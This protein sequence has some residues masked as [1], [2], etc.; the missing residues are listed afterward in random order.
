MNRA[1]GRTALA[2]ALTLLPQTAW[3]Q[4][5]PA[6]RGLSVEI[7]APR[8]NEIVFGRTRIVAEV[9]IDDPSR[10]DRVEFFLGDR[11]LFVDRE[12]P[13]EHLHDF[14]DQ[15]RSWVVRAVAH[16]REGVSVSHTVVTRK[17]TLTFVEE[18]NRIV[19]WAVV[20]DRDDRF[21][22]DL[23]RDSFR[24]LEDGKA[25]RILDFQAED[26][27]ITMAILLDTSGS[28]REQMRD[29]HAAAG[30]FVDTLR[31][32]DRALVIAFDDKVFL[33]QDLTADRNALKEA[34]TS[35]E[36]IGSTAVFDA[37]HAAYRKMR[38]IQG[39]KAI[40]LLSDGDDT[41]SNFGFERILE[42]AK[43]E[44]VIVYGIGLGAGL[45]GSGRRDVLR[46]FAEQTGGRAF[47][48]SKADELAGVYAAIADELR[49]Q[50]LITYSTPNTIWD[51]RWI[52]VE[53][54]SVPD[55]LKVRA[56][57]GYFAIKPRTPAD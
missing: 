35:T 11:L 47:F 22:T 38:G 16:H 4:D 14:G 29:V 6:R 31:D 40:V 32:Q 8:D 24:V 53:V 12:A 43:L 17:V 44:N 33:L 46:D 56:R 41:A 20:T 50:Y 49:K 34:V 57:K 26:R 5:A 39:R 27:P 10:L 28:M 9:R 15:P 3:A 48:V 2:L 36:A 54:Q 55:K 37:L 13:W 51:G 30:S 52:R 19:L 23:G 25:Q 45:G 18:V 7:T 1:T 42:E 21:V